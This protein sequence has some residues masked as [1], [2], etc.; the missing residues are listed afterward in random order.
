M[1]TGG[2][3]GSSPGYVTRSKTIKSSAKYTMRRV[4]KTPHA[5][6]RQHMAQW[7]RSVVVATSYDPW[8]QSLWLT[9]T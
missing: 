2:P 9:P 1:S 3:E 6:C 4:Q 5:H 7:F 8:L